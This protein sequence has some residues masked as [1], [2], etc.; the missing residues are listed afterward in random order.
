MHPSFS[1]QLAHDRIS[2]LR[3]QAQRALAARAARRVTPEPHDPVRSTAGPRARPGRGD[4]L[5]PEPT[6]LT[7]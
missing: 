1:Y 6:S 3:Q 4:V 7:A 5:E 2:D